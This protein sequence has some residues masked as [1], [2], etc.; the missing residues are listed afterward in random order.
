MEESISD[1]LKKLDLKKVKITTTILD[2]PNEILAKI[3]A[4]LSQEDII[5]N[6]AFVCKR[7]LCASRL[8][9][10]L[11]II[12]MKATRGWEFSRK[13]ANRIR[14]CVTIYPHCQLNFN[15]FEIRN[16]ELKRL[17]FVIPFMQRLDITIDFDCRKKPPIFE[18]IKVLNLE[19]GYHCTFRNII[20]LWGSFP[21]LIELKIQLFST[22]VDNHVSKAK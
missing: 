17:K 15:W 10:V 21:N 4:K 19:D 13:D 20:R 9:E 14:Q 1:S 12:Q 8:Q 7:F 2:L 22:M 18:N 16:S 6:V 5:K 3:L 11:P